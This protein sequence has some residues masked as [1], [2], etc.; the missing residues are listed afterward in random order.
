LFWA[1]ID[2]EHEE[3]ENSVEEKKRRKLIKKI[4]VDNFNGKLY[5]ILYFLS[6]INRLKK[7][8]LFWCKTILPQK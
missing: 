6:K 3:R 5:I 1:I 7:Y 8:A 2:Q 4:N